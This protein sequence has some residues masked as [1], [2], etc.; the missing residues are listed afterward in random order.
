M[1]RIIGGDKKECGPASAEELRAWIAEGRLNGQTLTREE[2]SVEWKTLADFPDFA[3]AL[4]GQT[5]SQSPP[6]LSP[7]PSADAWP[8]EILAREPRLHIGR[9]LARSG[10]LLG[11]NLGLLGGGASLVWLLGFVSLFVPFGGMAYW[12]CHGALDG[13]LCLV[14]LRCIRG[15]PAAIGDVFAGFKSNAAQL[16]LAGVVTSLLSR[17]ALFCCLLL[18]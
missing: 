14:F 2:Q 13:G 10:Q 1:Y 3:L 8:A 15:Q 9:C 12:I 5:A 18:P 7:P 11:S 4:R 6:P 16:I 17:I